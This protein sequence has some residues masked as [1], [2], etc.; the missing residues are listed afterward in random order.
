MQKNANNNDLVTWTRNHVSSMLM[1]NMLLL[2][3]AVSCSSVKLFKVISWHV[4]R[5]WPELKFELDRL[6]PGLQPNDRPDLIS[7]LF[8]IKLNEFLHVLKQE[9]RLGPVAA[10]VTAVEFQM[11]GLPH[12][13][14]LVWFQEGYRMHCPDDY[15]R[16]VRAEI[17]DPAQEPNLHALVKQHMLHC[18]CDQPRI[19]AHSLTSED[20]ADRWPCCDNPTGK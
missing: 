10:Y 14:T 18:R 8:R 9:G 1:R 20:R 17:P 12:A 3:R 16:V 11:R 7:R 15:D 4:M 5:R 2:I 19:S 13:H 6:G